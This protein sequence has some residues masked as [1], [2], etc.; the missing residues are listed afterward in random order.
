M[1]RLQKSSSHQPL[2]NLGQQFL[3][4]PVRLG[5]ILGA[6]GTRLRMVGQVLYG[7]QPIIGFLGQLE[8]SNT[9]VSVGYLHSR[10]QLS[11]TQPFTLNGRN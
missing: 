4:D 5:D 1:V 3:R 9:T 6:T 7:H 2:K 8:H 10:H 11:K